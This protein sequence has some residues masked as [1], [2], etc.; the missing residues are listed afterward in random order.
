MKKI[1]TFL[2]AATM[3]IGFAGV[4]MA[5]DATCS[6]C[7]APGVINRACP[8][9]QYECYA[10]PFDYEDNDQ[11]Y[12]YCDDVDKD[13]RRVLFPACDCDN[14]VEGD[15]ID[16][17][18]EILVNGSVGDNGAYWAEYV[19]S[20]GL[21]TYVS[22]T[23]ACQENIFDTGFQGAFDYLYYN[24]AGILTQGMPDSSSD[25][26]A[27]ATSDMQYRVTVIQPDIDDM[28]HGYTITQADDQGNLATWAIDIPWIKFDLNKVQAGDEISVRICLARTDAEGDVDLGGICGD[29]GCCCTFVVGT[30]GCCSDE[31][32]ADNELIYPYATPMNSAD[33]WF[34]FVITNLSS[35]DGEAMITVYETNSDLSVDT[36][37]ITVPVVGNGLYVTNNQGLMAAF[38][39]DIGDG[40]AYFVVETDF[41][42]SGF[43]FIGNDNKGEAMG[44]LPVAKSSLLGDLM[45]LALEFL[46]QNIS[47]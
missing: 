23:A 40:R 36:A 21:S 19:D 39:G 18:M 33:W 5:A 34:G 32:T 24:S 28:T 29:T 44:Y 13:Y 6:T 27:S 4:A 7:T 11:F 9:E 22:A 45:S 14:F 26:F 10:V 42:A 1:I 30:L 20:I 35:E 38:G 2:M 43:L 31:Y 46:P 3:I 25:C 41:D 37:T 12:N 16:I 47:R 15:T 17:R 8:A